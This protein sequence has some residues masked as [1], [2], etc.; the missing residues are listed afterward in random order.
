MKAWP[1]AIIRLAP[2]AEQLGMVG[3]RVWIIQLQVK[4][5]THDTRS[6]DQRTKFSMLN[7][8]LLYETAVPVTILYNLIAAAPCM[9][10]GTVPP[11]FKAA[12]GYTMQKIQ[13]SGV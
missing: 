6:L 3:P 5:M 10:N 11:V 9:A 8:H 2:A 12:P 13:S 1:E 4:Q 7:R